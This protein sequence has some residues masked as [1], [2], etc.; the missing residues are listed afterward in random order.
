M[1]LYEVI[2]PCHHYKGSYK[3]YEFHII[4]SEYFSGWYYVIYNTFTK[5]ILYNSVGAGKLYGSKD[6]CASACV[7]CID[8]YTKE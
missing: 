2:L 3:E 8:K 7:E 6:G 4:Y 1:K 5:S